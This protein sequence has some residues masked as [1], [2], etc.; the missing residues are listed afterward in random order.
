MVTFDGDKVRRM[1]VTDT[2]YVGT[3]SL[4]KD[5]GLITTTE[6]HGMDIAYTGTY[7]TGS[8]VGLNVITTGK[9]TASNWCS[10]AYFQM[11]LGTTNYVTGYAVAGEF[12]IKTSGT[13]NAGDVACI[14]LDSNVSRAGSECQSYIMLQDFGTTYTTNNFLYGL[15]LSAVAASNTALF[16]AAKGTELQTHAIRIRIGSTPYWIRVTSSSPV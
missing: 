2:V 14:M 13:S 1:A 7:T 8:L 6:T 9:G 5:A 3:I 15:G 16:C 12:E 4:T 10:A 11:V